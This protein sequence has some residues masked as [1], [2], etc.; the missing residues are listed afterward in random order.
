ME[1]LKKAIKE[2]GKVLPGN[3][4][5]VGSF[6]NNQMD[7]RLISEMGKDIYNRFKD[8]GVTKILTVEASGIG[9]ACLTAQFFDCNVV[10]AKKSKTANVDGDFFTAES[11]S[12]THKVSNTLIVPKEFIDKDDRI[13]IVD[14]FLANGKAVEACMEIIR[15]AGATLS[16]VAII[17]E[18]GFQGAGDRFREQG[19]NLYSLAVIDKMEGGEIIFRD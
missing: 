12:F 17:I 7:I 14:D 18:K 19:I 9:I 5:K 2:R 16:G 11:Y 8:C 13:L 3:V 4:L 10:F 1:L 6:L 15:Q